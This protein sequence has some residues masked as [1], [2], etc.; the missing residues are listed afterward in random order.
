MYGCMCV[1]IVYIHRGQ[2]LTSS[3]FLN[4]SLPFILRYGLSLEPRALLWE[5]LVSIRLV[6]GR[7]PLLTRV[8]VGSRDL[9]SGTYSKCST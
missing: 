8:Y 7:R 5:S 3:I 9:N 1:F 4:H 6:Q 2:R